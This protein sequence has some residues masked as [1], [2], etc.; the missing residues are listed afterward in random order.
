MPEETTEKNNDHGKVNAPQETK[1]TKEKK[2]S[3][4]KEILIFSLIAIVIVVPI[5]LYVAQPFIV[6]G[7]SMLPTFENGQYLIVDQL[8]YRLEKPRRGEVIIFKFPQDT[9]KFYI[10]RII[11]LPGETIEIKDKT[12]T[13]SNADAPLE[14]VLA[15]PYLDDKN[16]TSNFSK[17]TLA[18]DEYFVLGDNRKASSDSRTWGALPEDHIV[19]KALL[20]LFPVQTVD[21][22]PG[23]FSY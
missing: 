23:D 9:S 20:R 5:R 4:F 16:L 22:L 15:E 21:I 1:G 12:I 8:S 11:G 3:T 10:K 6:S 18:E 14:L 2:E 19:G 17:M 7:A 13:V